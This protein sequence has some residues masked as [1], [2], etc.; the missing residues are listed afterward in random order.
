M[1]KSDKG[2]WQF[3]FGTCCSRTFDS[4]LSS[5]A[6]LPVTRGKK[7]RYLWLE[8]ISTINID[9]LVSSYMKK[10]RFYHLKCGHQLPAPSRNPWAVPVGQLK[11]TSFSCKGNQYLPDLRLRYR[12]ACRRVQR[13]SKKFCHS[14][15][16]AVNWVG[17]G[18]F[19][20]SKG[21]TSSLCHRSSRTR[22]TWFGA[23]TLSFASRKPRDFLTWKRGGI[24]E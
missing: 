4:F 18:R 12:A 15:R 2:K 17:K 14:L 9:I 22:I 10:L 16:I 20:F 3:F 7:N 5:P 23:S 1:T 21:N 24:L 19:V 8:R 11:E 6:R 13:I